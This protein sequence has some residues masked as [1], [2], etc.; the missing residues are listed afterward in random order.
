MFF[1]VSHELASALKHKHK[2]ADSSQVHRGANF[3]EITDHL[4]RCTPESIGLA[5]GSPA[6]K[7]LAAVTR[8]YAEM[9]AL[10]L[11]RSKQ[12]ELQLPGL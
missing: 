5:E 9:L 6:I 7:S 11:H 2:D 3:K 12:P 4:G 10:R 8:S 1:N